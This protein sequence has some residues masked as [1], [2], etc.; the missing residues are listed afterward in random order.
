MQKVEKRKDG[1]R[2]VFLTFDPNVKAE[3]SRTK[4]EFAKDCDINH[5][6]RKYQKTGV[7]G[8]PLNYKEGQ[9][10]DFSDGEDFFQT[11]QRVV[12]AQEMFLSLP[13][14]IRNKFRNSPSEFLDFVTDPE[15]DE[16]C[17]KLKLKARPKAPETAPETPPVE[18]PEAPPAA[19]PS[20]PST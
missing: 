4:P 10:G 6:M 5:L 2:R 11:M 14:A 7:L 18:P 19:P 8:D 16:E 13:S 3:R 15:N 12:S 17:Y 20:T 1:S 9:Y